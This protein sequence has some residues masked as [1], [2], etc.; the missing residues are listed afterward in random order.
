MRVYLENASIVVTEPVVNLL[1]VVPYRSE[2][3][4]LYHVQ[5]PGVCCG[6]QRY[7]ARHGFDRRHAETLRARRI[8]VGMTRSVETAKL[9]RSHAPDVELDI[10]VVR[11]KLR[12]VFL[13]V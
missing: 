4:V 10:R 13:D 9:L 8:H 11:R 6:N 2:L 12:D 7:P 5:E 1:P 3:D